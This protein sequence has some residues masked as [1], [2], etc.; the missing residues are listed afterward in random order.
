[1]SALIYAEY[2]RALQRAG[3]LASQGRPAAEAYR[4]AARMMTQ[5]AACTTAPRA[6]AARLAR[7]QAHLEQAAHAATT[8]P[9]RPAETAPVAEPDFQDW[10]TA[11]IYRSPVSWDDIG[12]LEETQRAIKA[13][14]GLTL[15][16]KPQGVSL[17]G[18]RN[19]LFY[20][21]PGTGKTLLAAATSNGLEATFFNVVV[22]QLLSKYF[23]ESSR[24]ISALYRAA[25]SRAPAVIFLD[26]AEALAL[27]RGEGESGAERRMLSTL[28]AELDGLEQKRDERYVLTIAATNTPWLMDTAMLSRFEQKIYIPLPDAAARR[29]I[30]RIQLER[31]GYQTQL[32]YDE[33]VQ[34]TPGYSG[35]ELERLCRAA[36][37]HMVERANPDLVGIVEQGR[38]AVEAYQMRIEPLTEDDFGP[39]LAQV[40]PEI[41]PD[42]LARFDR[43]RQEMSGPAAGLIADR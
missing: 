43:W 32:G 7:A 19:L 17:Q 14:Y 9:A 3:Q 34:R 6:R 2:E 4:Q 28:L 35:R 8:P 1:M 42:Q 26:E 30:L 39:A 33:L 20:G 22:S 13:A 16:R 27:P 25:R 10:A 40:T 5:Y 24:L 36:I 18:W 29:A 21:P 15:A 37:H 31:Q 23:G 12:G 41:G 11:L 38:Q